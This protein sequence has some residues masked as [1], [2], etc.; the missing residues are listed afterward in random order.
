MARQT[1]EVAIPQQESKK[2]YHL[3]IHQHRVRTCSQICSGSNDAS[4]CRS[5]SG[6]AGPRA[7]ARFSALLPPVISA[8]TL[9]LYSSCWE[10]HHFK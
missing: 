9:H 2:L 1:C 10:Q 5:G 7:R 4:V 8:P 3:H 6:A